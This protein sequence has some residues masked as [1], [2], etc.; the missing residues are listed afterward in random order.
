[1]RYHHSVELQQSLVHSTPQPQRGGILICPFPSLVL[2]VVSPLFSSL[3]YDVGIMKQ[4]R[5]CITSQLKTD[6]VDDLFLFVSERK[7]RHWLRMTLQCTHINTHTHT[8][9]SHTYTHTE[10]LIFD[11]TVRFNGQSELFL[12]LRTSKECSH[13]I[14]IICTAR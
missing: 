8:S 13:C 4:E 10:S 2:V 1:M 3:Y 12:S 6:C 5:P 11:Q 7:A 9:T 14:L